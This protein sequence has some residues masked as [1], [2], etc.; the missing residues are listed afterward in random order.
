MN[1]VSGLFVGVNG[2]VTMVVSGGFRSIVHVK[3]VAELTFPAA[4]IA[5]TENVCEPLPSDE[6]ACG[7]R[8]VANAEPSSE[9]TNPVTPVPPVSVPEKL[10]VAVELFEGFAGF[11][12]SMVADGGTVSTIQVYWAGV[13][14]TLPA[15]SMARTLK[16]CDPSVS[17]V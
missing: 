7:D 12:S 2:L 11:G 13:A 5:F 10:N 4:S 1:V 8:H 17:P 15:A 3:V 9:Q 14:S 16:M 6:S